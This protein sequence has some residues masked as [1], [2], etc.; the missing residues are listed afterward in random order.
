MSGIGD[1][2]ESGQPESTEFPEREGRESPHIYVASLTDYNAGILHGTWL[3]ANDTV[4]GLQEGIDVML[5]TSPTAERYGEPAEEWAIHDFE[6]WGRIEVDEHESLATVTRLAEG[7][8]RHGEA[9]GA[10]VDVVGTT[11]AEELAQFEERYLGQFVSLEDYGDSL[12]AD[13]G[14]DVDDLPDVPEGLR[15]YVTI[16]VAGWVRDM[17]LNGEIRGV[18]GGNGV[19]VFWTI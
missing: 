19:Y 1:R 17:Q 4:E 5:A 6:G 7:L 10:Y 11:G 15:P 8:E 18:E 3:D 2:S 13:M 9:F 12:L 16:D 14:V